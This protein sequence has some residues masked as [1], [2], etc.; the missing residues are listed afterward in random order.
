M[1]GVTH[2]LETRSR[3]DEEESG[4][5]AFS[6]I[7]EKKLGFLSERRFCVFS[8]SPGGYRVDSRLNQAFLV[9]KPMWG[10]RNRF[11]GFEFGFKIGKG[12]FDL[13]L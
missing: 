12:G 13:W 3:V 8:T 10:T 5:K 7:S 4:E 9:S 11:C 1:P 6:L 2:P